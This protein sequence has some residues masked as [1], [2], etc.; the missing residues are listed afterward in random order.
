MP[1]AQPTY[2][3]T[4]PSLSEFTYVCVQPMGQ[5]LQMDSS[6]FSYNQQC[7]PYYYSM[8]SADF[9]S[10]DYQPNYASTTNST[11]LIE[12]NSNVYEPQI[13]TNGYKVEVKSSVETSTPNSSDYSSPG[14]STS[15]S[16]TS[17]VSSTVVASKLPP[18]I[19][20][21]VFFPPSA[22]NPS[23][24]QRTPRRNKFELNA[25]R[26]HHCTEPGKL[27]RLIDFE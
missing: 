10:S 21:K 5:Q 6:Q 13:D 17:S 26:V 18:D 9:Y 20:A 3:S 24:H 14:C 27:I 8:E 11:T 12:Q 22:L 2:S 25:K 15:P 1:T 7:P 23:G 19:A 16:S 4:Q